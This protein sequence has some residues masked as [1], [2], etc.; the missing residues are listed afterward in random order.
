MTAVNVGTSGSWSALAASIAGKFN[1][2]FAAKTK[3][4]TL[5]TSAA[6][7]D[8]SGAYSAS[9]I[10]DVQAARR[11]TLYVS[12][13]GS[14]AGAAG[15][16]C[17]IIPLVSAEDAEPGPVDDSWFTMGVNDGSVTGGVL[18]A[19]SLPS[20]TDFTVDPDFGRMLHRGLDIRSEPLDAN[21][22]KIRMRIALDVSGERW[23][24]ILYAAAAVLTEPETIAVKFS[25]SV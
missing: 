5:V 17:S 3:A 12:L 20:N 14:G 7:T 10:I 22:D 19:S 4:A 13:T 6:M 9:G 25:L 1:A 24:Q 8:T 21:T 16:V 2:P 11:L 18:T 23:V 15:A